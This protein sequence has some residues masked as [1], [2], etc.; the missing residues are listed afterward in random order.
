MREII[1]ITSSGSDRAGHTVTPV[2]AATLETTEHG[3]T[4]NLTSGGY[5]NMGK[6]TEP[7]LTEFTISSWVRVDVGTGQN[8]MLL[9]PQ[10]NS[11]S[12]NF[13]VIGSYY[14]YA[15]LNNG[16]YGSYNPDSTSKYYNDGKFHH[17]AITKDSSGTVRQF[18][19]G[20]IIYKYTPS[21]AAILNM[22]DGTKDICI[23][24]DTTAYPIIGKIAD[25]ILVDKC[26]W[27]NNFIPPKKSIVDY[28]WNNTSILILHGNE[29]WRWE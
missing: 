20:N 29:V 15:V 24:G 7:P 14:Y 6:I 2:G 13:I 27:N 11:S 21:P 28:G 8:A 17:Y 9:C 16:E 12:R 3:G 5:I 25:F 10:G 22:F 18:I 19:D 23:G 1:A 26:M 4:F